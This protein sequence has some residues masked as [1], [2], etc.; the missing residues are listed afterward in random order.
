MK[1]IKYP[2]GQLQANCYFVVEDDSCLIFDAGDSAD[3]LLEETQRLKLTPL[4][5]F[6]THGH[7]DHIMAVGEIQLSFDIPFYIAKEDLFL[8]KR[9]RETAQYF[10]GQKLA[11]VE[12]KRIEDFNEGT[13]YVSSFTFQVL[14]TPGHTP[15]ATCF[16]FEDK[17]WLLTGDTLFKGTIGRYDFSYSSK[18]DLYVSIHDKLFKLPDK[19]IIYPGHGEKTTIREENNSKTVEIIK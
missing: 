16:Y 11:I 1:I 6:A 13:F 3:F 17:S 9:A 2:V 5:I 15:G 12:P 19:T 14:R 7:F 4:A 10:L 8:V 18:K